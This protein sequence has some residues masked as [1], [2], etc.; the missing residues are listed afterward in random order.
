MSVWGKSHQNDCSSP[1]S[2]CDV[3]R[4]PEKNGIVMETAE[5]EKVAAPDDSKIGGKPYLPADFEWSTFRSAGDG[6]TR[7]SPSSARQSRTGKDI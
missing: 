1:E 4:S 7:R 2:L 3:I 6:I 5:N